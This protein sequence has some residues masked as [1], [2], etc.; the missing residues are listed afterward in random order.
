MEQIG[1]RGK[2]LAFNTLNK[3]YYRNYL[4]ELLSQYYQLLR[5]G[6]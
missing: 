5:P 2:E 6:L 3:A 4:I 1:K